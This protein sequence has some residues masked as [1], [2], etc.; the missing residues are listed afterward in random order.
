MVMIT[1]KN[2]KDRE[3]LLEKAKR[4]ETYAAMIV[5]CIEDSITEEPEYDE[6]NYR[7]HE[8]MDRYN[9]RRRMR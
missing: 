1:F 8:S 9:Y 3:H 5:D 2:S 4:M 6:K 7:E